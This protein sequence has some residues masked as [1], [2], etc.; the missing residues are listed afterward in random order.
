MPMHGRNLDFDNPKQ[1]RK[2]TYIGK[3]VNGTKNVFEATMF[4]GII[5]VYTGIKKADGAEDINFSI[6]EN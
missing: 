1:L 5:G 3:F 6:S 4:S 2:G